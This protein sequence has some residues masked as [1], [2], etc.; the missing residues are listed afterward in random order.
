MTTAVTVQRLA[1]ALFAAVALAAC[2]GQESSHAEAEG[3]ACFP[4]FQDFYQRLDALGASFTALGDLLPIDLS[5]LPAA[6]MTLAQQPGR[7]G[8][9]A[10]QQSPQN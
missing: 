10:L 4:L 7:E 3:A 1:I 6:P 8:L 5:T 9:I 2:S